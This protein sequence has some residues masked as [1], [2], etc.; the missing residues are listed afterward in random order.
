MFIT[1]LINLWITVIDSIVN[2]IDTPIQLL[3]GLSDTQLVQAWHN[4]NYC[5]GLTNCQIIFTAVGFY[6]SM[7]VIKVI[8]RI[9]R[10]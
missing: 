7:S 1:K 3:N 2:T 9:A 5:L 8:L 10:G 4:V 6:I